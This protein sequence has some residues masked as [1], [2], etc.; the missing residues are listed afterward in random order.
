MPR[1]I[2]SSSKQHLGNKRR[3]SP[4]A[5]IW[6]HKRGFWEFL[7]SL[8]DGALGRKRNDE[9]NLQQLKQ[10]MKTMYNHM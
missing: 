9:R 10:N 8:W 5:V 1:E 6:V 4:A 7:K 3:P 2:I